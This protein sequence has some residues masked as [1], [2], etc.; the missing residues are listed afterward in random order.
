[1]QRSPRP[2]IT[3]LSSQ[4]TLLLA[5]VGAGLVL[6]LVLVLPQMGATRAAGPTRSPEPA[7][8]APA[9]QVEVVQLV[10]ALDVE[11]EEPAPQAPIVALPSTT[12]EPQA[13]Q[14]AEVAKIEGPKLNFIRSSGKSEEVEH[15]DLRGP[16]RAQRKEQ[17]ERAAAASAQ[18][19]ATSGQPAKSQK[20]KAAPHPDRWRVDNR[21]GTGQ[22]GRG[23][24]KPK[25]G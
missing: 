24:G 2:S 1:M 8:P 20:T 19:F 14:P 17:R 6:F 3:G 5:L 10:R 16:R 22:A 23:K 21:S 15:K 18:G 11:P 25:G 9:A 4:G 13:E 7:E 12:A